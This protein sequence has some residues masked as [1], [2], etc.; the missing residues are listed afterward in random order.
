[1]AT[2]WTITDGSTTIDF[3]G[4][5][6]KVLNAGAWAPRVANR[7]KDAMAGRSVYEDVDENPLYISISGTDKGDV[8]GKL[9]TL[10]NLLD[11][12]AAWMEGEP[13]NP[14]YMSYQPADSDLAINLKGIIKGPPS[15][16]EFLSIPSHFDS[17]TIG[18]GVVLGTNAD[19][20]ILQ[21]RRAGLW[22][23]TEE[24][25]TATATTGNPVEKTLSAFSESAPIPWPYDFIVTF[26]RTSTNTFQLMGYYG[27][28][29][30]TNSASKII[31]FEAEDGSLSD[32]NFTSTA[33][34]GASNGYVMRMDIGTD[35]NDTSYIGET[36]IAGITGVREIQF[37]TMVR[38]NSSS[39][40][41]DVQLT[42]QETGSSIASEKTGRIIT[43]GTDNNDPQ[44][45]D[46]GTMIVPF[47][48]TLSDFN[49]Q[50][51][52]TPSGTVTAGN[53]LDVDYIC[54]IGIDEN[55]RILK[56]ERM[57]D[58]GNAYTSVA[59]TINH[60]LDTSF[61]PTIYTDATYPHYEA[62]DGNATLMAKG[63]TLAFIVLM[64]DDEK[65]DWVMEDTG[66]GEITYS[67]SATRMRAY[68]IPK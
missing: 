9:D 55:T 47:G 50:I 28:L 62:Y 8:L 16:G 26:A 29:A 33:V 66:A 64:H 48:A 18:G 57:L 31:F 27:Y 51:R 61:S 24:T 40:T 23:G 52:M 20:I 21:Y 34:T 68:L 1:M 41:Y 12:A 36:T 56:F 43:L 2:T 17:G 45:L 67:A 32:V 54:L 6:Y 25:E 19:P 35:E 14:V 4:S 63:N 39:L 38:N 5:N 65:A 11:Q 60:N 13:V 30:I 49:W 59:L 53:T 7:A 44:L 37:F 42:W 15:F 22:L 58:A 46:L 3:N 10:I